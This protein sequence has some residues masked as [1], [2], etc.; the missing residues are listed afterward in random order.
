MV[1]LD[2]LNKNMYRKYPLRSTS[3]L[4]ATNG[5][6]IPQALI[7][8]LQLST[9]FNKH[10]LYIS[11]IYVDT[12]F[13]S[14]TINNF[15]DGKVLGAFAG[16]VLKD[17]ETV[18]FV[19]QLSYLSGNLTTGTKQILST[20]P[21]GV[22]FIRDELNNLGTRA[23]G[24]L[25]DSTIFVFT[26][27]AV[28]SIAIKDRVLVGELT[29]L[30]GDNLNINAVSDTE[31]KLEVTD[32]N[33]VTSNNEF[34][35]GLDN[36]ATPII[37]KINTVYPS[38]TGNI[39]IYGIMPIVIN[40]E[41]GELGMTSGLDILDVCPE[42]KKIAPPLNLSDDYYTDILN[43]TTPEWKFWPNFS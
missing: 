6:Q 35:A 7:T 17:F 3:T 18:P 21:K 11:K 16:K 24:L 39:D 22:Y 31:I 40:V 36:C 43:T 4:I 41:T 14:I 37:K 38:S 30:K 23:D 20:I 32:V 26:P 10:K 19:T 1:N 13:I 27:P 33:S 2:F 25:E 8:S 42:K 9:V 28:E 5:M 15:N 29:T 12:G 34:S